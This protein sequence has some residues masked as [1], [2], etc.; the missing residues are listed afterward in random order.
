MPAHTLTLRV[1]YINLHP[2][3]CTAKMHCSYCHCQMYLQY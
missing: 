2:G 3:T 1:L